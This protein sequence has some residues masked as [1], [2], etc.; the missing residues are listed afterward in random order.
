MST[1][2]RPSAAPPAAPIEVSPPFTKRR[3]DRIDEPARPLGAKRAALQVRRLRA[4]QLVARAAAKRMGIDA[5]AL[6]LAS[7]DN[8]IAF[9]L[10]ATA[11]GLLIERTQRQPVGS[12]LARARRKAPWKSASA[13]ALWNKWKGPARV[14]RRREGGRLCRERPSRSCARRYGSHKGRPMTAGEANKPTTTPSHAS[15]IASD[16]RA[17]RS[18]FTDCGIRRRVL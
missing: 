6:I 17:S 9:S 4:S 1:D 5:G 15:G 2:C 13:R 16:S 11:V 7:K 3:I 8:S 12:R 14:K 10:R 18:V